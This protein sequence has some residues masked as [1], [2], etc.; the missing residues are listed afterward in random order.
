MDGMAFTNDFYGWN[1]YGPGIDEE[2]AG[3][4]YG[5]E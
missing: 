2:Q 4:D 1:L 3:L 5:N